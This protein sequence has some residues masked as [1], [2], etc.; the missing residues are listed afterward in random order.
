MELD[1]NVALAI[2]SHWIFA[3]QNTRGVVLPNFGSLPLRKTKTSKEATQID[4]L[5]GRMAG[6]NEFCLRGGD[7]NTTL[8]AATP[9]D[10]AAIQRH[11]VAS[12]RATGV[13]VSGKI[14]VNPPVKNVTAGGARVA[15]CE[16]GIIGA[17]QIRENAHGGCHVCFT[18]RM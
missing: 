16:A 17:S 8:T 2:T 1:V 14:A 5:L 6:R 18:G 9:A 12:H 3:H 11:E 4:I 10:W 7:G 13:R 15:V